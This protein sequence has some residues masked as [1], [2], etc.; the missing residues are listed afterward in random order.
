MINLLRKYS[1]KFGVDGAIIYTVLS[2][3]VQAGGGL[4]AIIFIA[5]N[6]TKYEQGYYFTFASIIAIQVFFE[7]GLSSIITQYTA[8][9]FA[10]LKF[11]EDKR[12][13]GDDYYKSRLSS[14]LQFCVKWFGII[15]VALFVILILV[16]F[17]F[18][19]NFNK[20]VEV[21]WQKPWI[22]LCLS[23]ALNLFIDPILA[24]YDGLGEVK[25]MAKVRLVQRLVNLVL[26]VCFFSLGLKLYSSALAS[27][28]SI[29]I[30]YVQILLSNRK[31]VLLSIWR[32]KSEWV[33]DYFK[34]IFPYQWRIAVSW[35][36]GYFIY[37]LFNP[38]L[39]ATEGPVVA[40]QMGITIQVLNGITA[41]VMSWITTK[42][43]VFS[44]LIATK[45][46]NELD[47]LFNSTLLRVS[48]VY[49]FFLV[50]FDLSIWIMNYANL[51]YSNRFL[52]LIPTIVLSFIFLFNQIIF[53]WATYIRCHKIEPYLLFS[54]VFAVLTSLSTFL[55]G[56]NYGLNGIIGGYGGLTVISFIISYYIFIK[57]KNILHT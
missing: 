30:N 11:S 31:H 45:K 28:I 22:I 46:Y 2:R 8:H 16:G 57:Q 56:N 49:L 19:L 47:I 17:Y 25:D 34:E 50:M 21:E 52:P 27:V 55:L 37:Q 44:N 29:G 13:I 12:L 5:K 51:P 4:I 42:I 53:S 35:I 18:F 23:T 40:G 54:I 15:S 32:S 24:F 20:N 9:E 1:T 14:L 38:V 7:L 48:G 39:F 3:L 6:L 10:H 41:V 36:S 26:L 43:P 33:I